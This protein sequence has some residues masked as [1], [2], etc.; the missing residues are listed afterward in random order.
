[1]RKISLYI[2][3]FLL[4]IC[5][6]L[7]VSYAYYAVYPNGADNIVTN[8]VLENPCI[9]FSSTTGSPS[10]DY[11]IPISDAKALS[12]TTYRKTL[13]IKN[14]CA[15]NEEVKIFFAPSSTSTVPVT[16]LKY[17]IH[18]S[19]ETKPTAGS[20]FSTTFSF[21][22]QTINDVAT[23]TGETLSSGYLMRTETISH[24]STSTFYVYVWIDSAEGGT[25]NSTANKKLAF[26]I[27]VGES[28]DVN[29]PKLVNYLIN[30]APKSGTDAVSSS[31]WILTSDREGEWRYAG[32][33]PDNYL[34]FNG[35]LWRIIGVMPNTE[36]CTGTY[37]DSSCT[38][39][40]GTGSLVKIVRNDR[41]GAGKWD[42][43]GT[44]NWVSASLNATLQAK[45]YAS[46]SHVAVVKWS[47]YGTAT[48][49][50]DAT[51]SPAVW[52][53]KERNIN[54]SGALYGS[55]P[56]YWYGKVGLPYMSDFGYATN[57]NGQESGTNSRTNCLATTIYNWS[58]G[59][60][61][62]DN[63]WLRYV[64]ITSSITSG[65]AQA[66]QWTMTQ[67]TGNSSSVYGYFGNGYAVSGTTSSG[68]YSYRP[69]LYLSSDTMIGGGS[70]TYSDPYTVV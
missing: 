12:G 52:Y 4:G 29:P 40:S 39:T 54:S 9:Q 8:V 30:D 13:T 19:S 44:N 37:T 38:G 34:Q 20:T 46:D 63:G 17:A 59:T 55:N 16:A 41:D 43:N 51:G 7:S 48:D 25:P 65:S 50:T 56:A 18:K 53:N 28:D 1:M 3:V 5:T 66:S 60:P 35:E 11:Q 68:T 49:N 67:N 42:T 2:I 27:V 62:N 45:T 24:G 14:V 21:N 57:G 33:N 31:P 69:T 26:H 22:S 61:C 15:T 32:L 70:G 23:V 64:N 36:Y 47:L 58:L 6:L 10:V